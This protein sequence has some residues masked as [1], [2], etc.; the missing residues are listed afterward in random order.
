MNVSEAVILVAGLIAG[1]ALAAPLAA[2]LRLPVSI[3]LALLGIAI[4]LF[5]REILA[6]EEAAQMAS[7]SPGSAFFLFLLLPTLLYQSSLEIDFHRIREDVAPIVILALV[8]VL[9]AT[10]GIALALTPFTPLPTI[11]CLLL[12]SIVATTDP[13]AVIGIFRDV[14][15]P[16]RLTRLVEGESLFNDAV[17]ISLF[18]V[19]TAAIADPATMGAGRIAVNFLWL[20][21]GGALLGILVARVFVDLAARLAGDR[22]TVVSL[23]LA[24]PFF[25]FWLAEHHLH[26]SGVIAVVAAGVSVAT[27]APGRIPNHVWS[28]H[29]DIWEQLASWA[30]ILVFI[31]VSMRVPGLL[32]TASAADALLLAVVF[33]AALAARALIVFGLFPLLD[34]FGVYPPVSLPFRIVTLWGGLRGTM[35]LTLALAVTENPGIPED[36]TRFVA[37]LATGYTLATLFVQGVTLR[38]LIQGLGLNRLTDVDR[39]VRDLALTSITRRIL[40][41]QQT[42]LDRFRAQ[43]LEVDPSTPV[44]LRVQGRMRGGSDIELAKKTAIGLATTTARER[45]MVLEHFARGTLAARVSRR[46]AADARRRTDAARHGGTAAY[47]EAAARELDFDTLDRLAI[48]LQRRLGK[49]RMLSGRLAERFELLVETALVLSELP[50]FVEGEVAAILGADVAERVQAELLL[51]RQNAER[52]MEALTLQYPGYAR[53]VQRAMAERSIDAL[54]LSEIRRLRQAGIINSEIERDLT[55]EVK[56]RAALQSRPALDLQL[57]RETLIAHCEIL[58]DLS[59]EARRRLAR[60]LRPFFSGPGNTII[61]RGDDGDAAYFVA[62][63]SVEVDTGQAVLRIGR[64]EVVGEIALLF[65]VK[66]QAD[67][68]TLGYST[69]LRLS[70]ADFERFLASDQALKKRIEAT[71]RRR[72]DQN[73]AGIDPSPAEIDRIDEAR[74]APGLA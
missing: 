39:A 54:E 32:A 15:A 62:S 40:E 66:R 69:L 70:R 2:R 49:G 29:T 41:R 28:Y 43:G 47:R 64:G 42:V 24:V 23:S 71:A 11:A 5:G 56:A 55:R 60:Y 1:G 31:L 16:D 6:G 33:T 14:G 7:L 36:I 35:T 63:G 25:C 61:R 18:L 3:V 26:V 21:V 52:E 20:P 53:D 37:V 38:P 74:V 59:E 34:R 9:V 46:M 50:A 48:V 30:T 8:A 4:G 65:D 72:M 22:L 45:E 13:V 51:R 10:F 73:S 27:L 12:A 17:A 68:T 67:V 58:S 57:D 44:N 19:F